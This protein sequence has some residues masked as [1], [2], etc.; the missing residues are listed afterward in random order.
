M[1]AMLFVDDPVRGNPLQPTADAIRALKGE[2]W[3]STILIDHLLQTT[4]KGCV[5]DHVLIGSSDCYEYFSTYNDKLD[6]HDCAD[7]VQ[8]MRGGLQAYAKSEFS[9]D[10]GL[11]AVAVIW[12][13]LDGKEVHSS[14]FTQGNIATLRQALY[15]GLSANAEWATLEN[16]SSFFPALLPSLRNESSPAEDGELVDETCQEGEGPNEEL[17]ARTRPENSICCTNC[18]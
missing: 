6:K 3:L 12:H 17:V 13:L 14:V 7:T 15:R 5:P 2:E 4:L 18:A 8:T 9:H 11:F 10:C 1:H 16:V